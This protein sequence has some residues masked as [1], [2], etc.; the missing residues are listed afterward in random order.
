VGFYLVAVFFLELA[1]L[2]LDNAARV[3]G[4]GTPIY[5]RIPVIPRY[6]DSDENIKAICNFSRE[7]VSVVEI[8]LLP[9]HHL[10]QARYNCLDLAYPLANVPLVPD[11]R[12][13]HL[14]ELVYSFVCV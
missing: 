14:Q 10:G 11:D 13:R 9:L 4:K 5:I 7:L 2:I 8:D 1:Q 3:S 12:M 6:T